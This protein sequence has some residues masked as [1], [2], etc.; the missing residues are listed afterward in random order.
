MNN[1]GQRYAIRPVVDEGS[2]YYRIYDTRRRV[3][4]RWFASLS[5]AQAVLTVLER[6]AEDS[7]EAWR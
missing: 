6:A 4:L 7:P 3:T 1:V 2:L 5:R